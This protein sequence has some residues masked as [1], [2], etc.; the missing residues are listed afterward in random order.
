MFEKKYIQELAELLTKNELTEL[1]LK[2][3]DKELV[4]RKEKEVVART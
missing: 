4:L 2:D 3:G 1:S